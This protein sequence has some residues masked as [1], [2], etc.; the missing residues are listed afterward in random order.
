MTTFVLSQRDGD[1]IFTIADKFERG[2]VVVA[3]DFMSECFI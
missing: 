1:R 3:E 2:V